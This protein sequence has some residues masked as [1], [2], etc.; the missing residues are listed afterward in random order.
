MLGKGRGAKRGRVDASRE[1]PPM[2]APCG[3]LP[4]PVTPVQGDAGASSSSSSSCES[5]SSAGSPAA[6]S[7][8]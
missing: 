4:T 8:E 5:L 3:A 1:A 2:Q 6:S 7:S